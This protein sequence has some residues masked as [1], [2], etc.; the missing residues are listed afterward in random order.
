MRRMRFRCFQVLCGLLCLTL[1]FASGFSREANAET[2]CLCKRADPIVIPGPTPKPM[3]M[4]EGGMPAMST[5]F[6]GMP[7]EDWIGD[8]F[9]YCKANGIPLAGEEFQCIV[10]FEDEEI[11][12]VTFSRNRLVAGGAEVFIQIVDKETI[13][14]WCV[15]FDNGAATTEQTLE[16]LLYYFP[17]LVQACVYASEETVTMSEVEEIVNQLHPDIRNLFLSGES[18]ER[19]IRP[20][21]TFYGLRY[22]ANTE[23]L[24]AYGDWYY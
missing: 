20:H 4:C 1:C 11:P 12:G 23:Y 14:D 18:M 6:H 17:L 7:A 3:P 15:L 24:T 19:K 16:T 21:Q 8:F 2:E 9:R 22:H 13:N 5:N 10:E